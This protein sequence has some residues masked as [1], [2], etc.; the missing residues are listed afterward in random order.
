MAYLLLESV[1]PNFGLIG[2]TM[3][4]KPK[5]PVAVTAGLSEKV[6]TAIDSVQSQFV[7]FVQD[8]TSLNE[9]REDL[10]P[11]FMKAFGAWQSETGGSFVAFVR[12][13][14]PDVPEDREG[15]RAHRAYQAADYLRRLTAA[16]SRKQETP[17]DRA[18]RI[19]SRPVSPQRAMARMVAAVLPL[20]APE[21]LD[22]LWQ[23]MQAELRWS[24]QQVANLQQTTS[25]E[26]PLVQLRAPAGVKVAHKLR[27][28]NV[29]ATEKAA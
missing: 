26:T 22:K 6:Q 24:E 7:N 11:K 4:K 27:V 20:L 18:A 21:T 23:A 16:G 25:E 15:Y 1:Q 17:V 10:A 9:S 14:V 12:L 5:K 8:F 13:L 29:S 19:A 28:V 3:A 2:V